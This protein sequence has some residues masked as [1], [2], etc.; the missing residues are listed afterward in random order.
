[1][2]RQS[3]LES[4]TKFTAGTKKLGQDGNMWEITITT[5]GVKR[6]NRINPQYDQVY[7]ALNK[8]WQKLVNGFIT[9]D[10][11]GKWRLITSKLKSKQANV[12]DIKEMWTNVEQDKNVVAIIWT[13]Q[14]RDALD[15][16]V[17]KILK[18]NT[19]QNIDLLLKRKKIIEHIMTNH[20]KYFKKYPFYT[21]KDRTI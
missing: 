15:Y 3:P 10:K 19:K 20:K 2:T 18:K 6:W 11:E 13:A 7:S 21:H 8:W 16:L 4:A 9:I 17:N 14:S 1:M 12:N 5:N